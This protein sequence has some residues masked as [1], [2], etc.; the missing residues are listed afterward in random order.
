M[1]N[2]FCGLL[3]A[4]AVALAIAAPALAQA[5]YPAQQVRVIVPYAAGGPIDAAGRPAM[6]RLQRALGQPVIMDFRAGGASITGTQA[7]ARADPDGYTLL[8]TAAQH[9]INPSVHAR[10]PYDPLADFVA[11]AQV[12]AGP[13]MLV[14]HPGLKAANLKELIALA[15][16]SPKKLNYASAGVGSGF[17]M[18]MEM[19]KTQAGID[20]VHVPYKGGAPATNDLV[21][22]HV[23]AMIGSAVVAPLIREGQLRVLA[24]TTARR[25]PVLP[26]VPTM[27][28]QGVPGYDTGTWFGVLAPARTPKAIVDRLASEIEKIVRAPDYVEHLRKFALEPGALTPAGFD[29]ILRREVP[30]WLEVAKKAGITPAEAK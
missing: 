2:V 17:H 15:K 11:I 16:A 5:T 24:V 22:G 30:Q 10:L 12:A 18:A 14:V 23:D 3:T 1:S 7:V 9:T 29:A 19:L 8:F 20:M 6:D 25:S 26:D 27:A 4:A 13:L 28:E 21:A